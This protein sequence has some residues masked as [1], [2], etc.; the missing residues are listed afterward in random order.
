MFEEEIELKW[1]K[2]GCGLVFYTDAQYWDEKEGDFDEKTTDDWDVDMSV[3]YDQSKAT[4]FLMLT[5]SDLTP[6]GI[7]ASGD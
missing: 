2:G 4:F 7:F 6:L 3:Y 1:E 5:R